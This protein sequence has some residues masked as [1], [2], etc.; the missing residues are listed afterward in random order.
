[1]FYLK[2]MYSKRTLFCSEQERTGCSVFSELFSLST[3]ILGKTIIATT[4]WTPCSVLFFLFP[5]NRTERLTAQQAQIHV[6][7]RSKSSLWKNKL[8]LYSIFH[9]TLCCCFLTFRNKKSNFKLYVMKNWTI[10]VFRWCF[11]NELQHM[12]ILW[13]FISLGCGVIG[14]LVKHLLLV[15]QR[16][17]R[18]TD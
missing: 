18:F 8:V 5:F 11:A 7:I 9:N 4:F 10:T 15:H 16:L 3:F 17:H 12:Q 14:S 2:W 13:L 6:T 1:M